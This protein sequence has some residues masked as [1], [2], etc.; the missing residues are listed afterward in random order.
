LFPGIVHHFTSA[1]ISH[2]FRTRIIS[3][4][5]TDL[6]KWHAHKQRVSRTI[7]TAHKIVKMPV[8]ASMQLNNQ[9]WNYSNCSFFVSYNLYICKFLS[10]LFFSILNVA[11]IGTGK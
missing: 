7:M 8:L 1:A 4:H 11:T 6:Y 5:T 3:A 10:W 9:F 2:R